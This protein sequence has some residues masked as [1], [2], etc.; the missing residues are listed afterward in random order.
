MSRG[1]CAG[2]N[3]SMLQSLCCV[4]D[5]LWVREGDIQPSNLLPQPPRSQ[6]QQQQAAINKWNV[7]M[8]EGIERQDQMIGV[9]VRCN[10]IRG[11]PDWRKVNASRTEQQGKNLRL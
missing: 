3:V 6:E 10:T 8:T 7:H 4:S 2:H 5:E 1:N 9:G 11:I